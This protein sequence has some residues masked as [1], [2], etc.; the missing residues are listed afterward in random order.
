MIVK[1][2]AHAWEDP[3]RFTW[4]GPPL[5][6]AEAYAQSFSSLMADGQSPDRKRMRATDSSMPQTGV[7]SR[8]V[9][10]RVAPE[11]ATSVPASGPEHK[12]ARPL[13]LRML[14]RLPEFVA[15]RASSSPALPVASLLRMHA[16][17][18]A[19]ALKLC[20]PRL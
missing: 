13:F 2:V 1:Q 19:D 12:D 9:I 15:L 6:E 4:A 5:A 18:A 16:R 11:R 3:S 10:P 20:T 17:T 14:P 7:A 8:R